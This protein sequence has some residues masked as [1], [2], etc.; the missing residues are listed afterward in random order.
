MKA[1]VGLSPPDDGD[2]ALMGLVTALPDWFF[3]R[4]NCANVRVPGKQRLQEAGLSRLRWLMDRDRPLLDRTPPRGIVKCSNTPSRARYRIANNYLQAGT[5]S[6]T[7]RALPKRY[8]LCMQRGRIQLDDPSP[9]RENSASPS[10]PGI[11]SHPVTHAPTAQSWRV[12][13]VGLH[14]DGGGGNGCSSWGS[15][16]SMASR[17]VS[18][19]NPRVLGSGTH[20]GHNAAC[21]G[22][23]EVSK[24]GV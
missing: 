18:I 6:S 19:C 5:S 15:K 9:P 11:S 22:G 2:S 12:W 17:F 10:Q 7:F 14:R 4:W 20:T 16:P 8:V 23:E 3:A 24:F 13:T 21:F 1:R